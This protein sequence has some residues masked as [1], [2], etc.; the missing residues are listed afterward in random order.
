MT[1]SA[2]I[3]DDNDPIAL[4]APVAYATTDFGHIALLFLGAVVI[5]AALG[6]AA[7]RGIDKLRVW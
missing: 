1:Y 6:Y 2:Y 7:L 4:A 3:I 5:V